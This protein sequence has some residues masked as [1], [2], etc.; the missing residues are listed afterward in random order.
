MRAAAID[1]GTNTIRL[2][3]ADLDG[4]DRLVP[5][6]REELITRL[7]EGFIFNRSISETAMERTIEGLKRFKK[8][9]GD[10][11]PYKVIAVGTSVVREARNGS[12]FIQRAKEETGIQVNLISGEIEATFAAKG[13][14]L[15]VTVEFGQ[16]FIFDIGGGSTEFILTHGTKVVKVESI[17]LG[18]VHLAEEYLHADPPRQNE[19]AILEKIIHSK[20][21]MVRERF[22]TGMMCP[23]DSDSMTIL[24]GIAGTPTTLAAI[25]LKLA[26]YDRERATNHIL[27]TTRITEI[28]QELIGKSAAERL[29][30]PGLQKGRE[31]L[32]VPGT[33]IVR[34]IM[35]TFGLSLLRVIDSGILEGLLLSTHRP[36]HQ[37]RAFRGDSGES[38]RKY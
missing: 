17:D 21:E 4:K 31:D 12:I 26:P 28:F 20:I 22:E 2:L 29:L 27:E 36:E 11:R 32:I 23:F 5:I 10:Y 33:M 13:A 30:T 19:M 15:P 3:V 16:A 24:V 6:H 35:N 14:L 18:V 25:D 37:F 38:G 34:E 1:V 9:M 7:G 8:A